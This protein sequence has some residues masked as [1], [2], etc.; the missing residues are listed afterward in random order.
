MYNDFLSL[1]WFSDPHL[2]T[3]LGSTFTFHSSSFLLTHI[4]PSLRLGA[5]LELRR[6]GSSLGPS[7][8]QARNPSLLSG[9][10][11]TGLP[12]LGTEHLPGAL[13]SGTGSPALGLCSP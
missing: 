10:L 3:T 9:V 4:H 1:L 5:E 2:P 7:Q 11:G 13:C 6:S 12:G 8:K